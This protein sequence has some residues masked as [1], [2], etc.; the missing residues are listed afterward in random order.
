MCTLFGPPARTKLATILVHSPRRRGPGAQ[1]WA[2]SGQTVPRNLPATSMGGW[3]H[4]L[5]SGK[6]AHASSPSLNLCVGW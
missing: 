1:G 5:F 4:E 3:S 6:R 2:L